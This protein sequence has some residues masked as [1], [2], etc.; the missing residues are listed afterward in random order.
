MQLNGIVILTIALEYSGER[1]YI[2]YIH[3]HLQL[4]VV[5]MELNLKRKLVERYIEKRN[6]W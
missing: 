4:Q 1:C 6:L 2:G 5:N 3:I